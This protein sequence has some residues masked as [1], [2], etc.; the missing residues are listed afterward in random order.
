MPSLRDLFVKMCGNH[1]LIVI[2]MPVVG[3]E[4]WWSEDGLQCVDDARAAVLATGGR[5]GLMELD[6]VSPASNLFELLVA[7]CFVMNLIGC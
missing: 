3:Y 4:K 2:G 6:A 1:T 7:E 5:G